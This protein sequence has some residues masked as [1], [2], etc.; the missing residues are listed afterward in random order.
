MT[1]YYNIPCNFVHFWQ[2]TYASIKHEIAY[3]HEISKTKKKSMNKHKSECWAELCGENPE[4]EIEVK[5]MTSERLQEGQ[6]IHR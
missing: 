1:N 2:W 3:K 6:N 4:L 5:N